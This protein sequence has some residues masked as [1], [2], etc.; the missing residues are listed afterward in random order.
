MDEIT[1]LTQAS[2]GVP[3]RDNTRYSEAGKYNPHNS[4]QR[5]EAAYLNDD[6]LFPGTIIHAVLISRIDTDYPGP[7]HARVTENV[8]DSMTGK[9]LLIPQGT[10]L[11]GNYSSSSIGVSKV[12]IAWES[13]VI[14]YGGTAY[15]VSLGGMAGVDKRGR[16]GI[17]GTLDDHYFEWLKAAG[18][19]S[20]FTLLNSEIMYQTNGQSNPQIRELMDINQ[21]IV[22]RIGDRLIERA[23]DIQPTVRVANG[24]AVSVSVNTAVHLKPFPAIPAEEKWIR[25]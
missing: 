21:G 25:K 17:A 7:I 11:Q 9:N 12:Q 15:Q 3:G 18:A 5:L 2:G 14:N 6:C 20:F 8:Y 13:M 24:T 4:P 16:A 1:R 19:I 10:V 22:N 23:L